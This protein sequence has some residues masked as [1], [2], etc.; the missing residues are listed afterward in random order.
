MGEW[1]VLPLIA[2]SLRGMIGIDESAI[3]DL[4]GVVNQKEGD[5]VTSSSMFPVGCKLSTSW[6]TI[7]PYVQIHG[8]FE[9]PGRRSRKRRWRWCWCYGG[10]EGKGKAEVRLA[11]Y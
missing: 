1:A 3:C 7:C 2:R 4:Q 5:Y 6:L 11:A 10:R 9:D 8:R